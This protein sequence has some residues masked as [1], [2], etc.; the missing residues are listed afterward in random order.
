MYG[1]ILFSFSFVSAI[2]SWTEE[3]DLEDLS[4]N[5]DNNN[6][7]NNIDNNNNHLYGK[8]YSP[9]KFAF[10]YSAILGVIFKLIFTIGFAYLLHFGSDF[11][12]KDF[13]FTKQKH[14][15]STLYTALTISLVLLLILTL[16]NGIVV[17]VNLLYISIKTA[18]DFSFNSFYWIISIFS[19][20]I[21]SLLLLVNGKVFLNFLNWSSI[22]LFG[23][24][25]FI[26]PLLLYVEAI[27]EAEV[28]EDNYKYSALLDFKSFVD[29]KYDEISYYGNNDN[30]DCKLILEEDNISHN[31]LKGILHEVKTRK[32]SE[33]DDEAKKKIVDIIYQSEGYYSISKSYN[34][35]FGSAV[36]T[37]SKVSMILYAIILM[38]FVF[39]VF[40]IYFALYNFFINKTLVVNIFV[41]LN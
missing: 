41:Q 19:P 12:M 40:S 27:G 25:N 33:L 17:H 3:T 39:M 35:L 38:L 26:L 1:T 21:L 31:N 13:L 11:T 34:M 20:W 37:K 30:E 4:T 36:F 28:F 22:F 6:L 32:E 24:V 23:Y 9:Q 2:P 7:N 10:K 14:E 16:M 29:L 18:S 8:K 15:D 5:I